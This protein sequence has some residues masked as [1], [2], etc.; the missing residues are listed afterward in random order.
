MS[1]LAEWKEPEWAIQ[2]HIN[3]AK[4]HCS[5][6]LMHAVP[7]PS[8]PCFPTQLLSLPRGGLHTRIEKLSCDFPALQASPTLLLTS[9]ALNLNSHK[10]KPPRKALLPWEC[11]ADGSWQSPATSELGLRMEWRKTKLDWCSLEHTGKGN[12][13][14]DSVTLNLNNHIAHTRIP[15]GNL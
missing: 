2:Y 13:N 6:R 11:E 14:L 3:C 8:H 1:C 9:E 12:I 10:E 5:A 7:H 4:A 15:C